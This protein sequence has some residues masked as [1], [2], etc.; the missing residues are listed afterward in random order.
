M[1]PKAKF[2]DANDFKA[3][4]VKKMEMLPCYMEQ[5]RIILNNIITILHRQPAVDAVTV[6]RCAEC[7]FYNTWLD[8]VTFCTRIGTYNGS[9]SPSDFCSKGIRR[10]RK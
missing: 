6:V 1:A 5:Q 3:D 7:K 4:L 9:M 2:I 10:E 8:G